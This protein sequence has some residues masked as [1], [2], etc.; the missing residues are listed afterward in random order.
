MRLNEFR[1]WI[2]SDVTDAQNKFTSR[3]SGNPISTFSLGE[4]T[5]R[6]QILSSALETIDITFIEG[7]D[8]RAFFPLFEEM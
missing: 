1:K 6:F 4:F 5:Q 3:L 7:I 8:W 2:Q